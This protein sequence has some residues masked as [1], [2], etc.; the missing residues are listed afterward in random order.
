MAAALALG[1]NFGQVKESI[2]AKINDTAATQF[3]NSCNEYNGNL[4]ERGIRFIKRSNKEQALDVAIELAEKTGQSLLLF[5]DEGMLKQ[6][7]NREN[8]LKN[9]IMNDG[10][11][12]VY[13]PEEEL[14]DK[15][16]TIHDIVFLL[17]RKLSTV[18][19]TPKGNFE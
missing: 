6:E 9:L 4:K 16:K 10:R 8:V 17:G 18:L 14:F 3:E 5:V 11:I 15:L 19:V 2:A 13:F 1:L 12:V 7:L